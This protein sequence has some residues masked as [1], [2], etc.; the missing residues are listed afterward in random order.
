M[1]EQYINPN[2]ISFDD[3]DDETQDSI[4]ITK[5]LD[6][7][8]YTS[9]WT[10]ETIIGQMEKGNIALN[11]RFQRRDAWTIERKSL[12]IESLIIG[13]P[14]PQIV[15]AE[16]ERGKYIVIDGKQRLLALSQFYGKSSSKNNNYKLTKLEIDK[17][18]NRKSYFELQANPKYSAQLNSLNNQ[19]IRAVVIRNAPSMDFLH[20]VFWRL[21]TGSV[22][23]SPQELRLALYQGSFSDFIDDRAMA[24][25]VIK[26]LLNITEPDF[27]MR[28]VELLARF[29]GFINFIGTYN[30]DMWDFLN[31]TYQTLNKK[32]D[33]CKGIIEDQVRRFEDGAAA[34]IEIFGIN[35]VARRPIDEPRKRF[36]RAIFDVIVYYF[37]FEQ[38]ARK[39]IENKENVKRSFTELWNESESFKDSVERTTK[40]VESVKTRYELWGKKL[41]QS[42]GIEIE[43]PKIP[44]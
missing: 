31:K 3:I 15:L 1:S 22:K 44:Q 29:I 20:T 37:S 33:E 27:R 8:I 13:I 6:A 7:V 17:T 25:L 30:G 23:L 36:N 41:S 26:R 32:W 21:N 39:A 24:S 11:P 18:L 4:D 43:L 42:I 12:F 16:L 35:D 38:V 14:V 5:F 19:T 34:A 2:A 28:D 10:T 40:S 9:D